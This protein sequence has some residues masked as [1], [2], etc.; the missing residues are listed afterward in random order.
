MCLSRAGRERAGVMPWWFAEQ[1]AFAEVYVEGVRDKEDIVLG[2][3]GIRS[4][5]I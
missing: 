2:K 1:G 4:S 5:E 3:N